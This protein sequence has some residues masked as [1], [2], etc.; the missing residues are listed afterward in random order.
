MSIAWQMI[1]GKNIY[2]PKCTSKDVSTTW[3]EIP[4]KS[5][6]QCLDCG[7]AW[8]VN[9]DSEV[10]YKDSVPVLKHRKETL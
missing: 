8:D 7:H 9:K 1:F 6:M 5:F 4:S 10:I 3:A 2:C